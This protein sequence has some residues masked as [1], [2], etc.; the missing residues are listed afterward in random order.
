[1]KLTFYSNFLNHHHIPLCNYFYKV[2]GD[3]FKFV[4]VEQVPQERISL[5]YMTDFSLYPY[6]IESYLS[7]DEYSRA[8]ELGLS[9]DAVIIGSSHEVFIKE[10]I[11]LNKLTFRY[12]ERLFKKGIRYLF[13]PKAIFKRYELDT[14]LRYKNVWMLS[15][16]AYTPWDFSFYFAYPNRFIKWGYFPETISYNV[17]EVINRK[18]NDIY[19]FLW[20]GR[21]LD[22]KRPMQ[23]IQLVEKLVEQGYPAKLDMIG[24]GKELEELKSY[25]KSKNLNETIKFHGS[26]TPEEVRTFM[27]KSKYFLFTSNRGEGWGAVLNEAMNSMC[28]VFAYYQIGSAPYLI[29]HLKDGVMYKNTKDLHKLVVNLLENSSLQESIAKNAYYKITRVWSHEIAAERFLIFSK[30]LLKQKICFFE[31][32]PLSKAKRISERKVR[33]E[34]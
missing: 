24:I 13:H 22:W 12:S 32:G 33:H 4:A 29:D 7:K 20:V 26:K 28:V 18:N 21:F 27:L 34:L 9:S 15:S 3:N 10:R 8:I 14:R 23:A 11:S 16:S 17:D 1:M 5:G 6:L 19:S 25:V 30:E 31:N 2:L